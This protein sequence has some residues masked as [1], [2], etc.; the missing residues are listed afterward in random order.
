MILNRELS[1]FEKLIVLSG[2]TTVMFE[3]L[4]EDE[5]VKDLIRAGKSQDELVE[6]V[7]E[8]Y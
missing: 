6:Y 4:A 3:L 1:L 2:E 8:N 7:N 5:E